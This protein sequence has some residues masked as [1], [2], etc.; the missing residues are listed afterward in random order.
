MRLVGRIL[1]KAL[2][3]LYFFMFLIGILGYFEI[4]EF[5]TNVF[6]FFKELLGNYALGLPV[7]CLIFAVVCWL[8]SGTKREQEFDDDDDDDDDEYDNRYD[9]YKRKKNTMKDRPVDKARSTEQARSDELSKRISTARSREVQANRL[10]NKAAS[11][12]ETGIPVSLAR[13]N[14]FS[15]YFAERL[16]VND[17]PVAT[18]DH[19]GH[20]GANFSSYFGEGNKSFYISENTVSMNGFKDYFK[21]SKKDIRKNN[22]LPLESADKEK[23]QDTLFQRNNYFQERQQVA[24]V[25]QVMAATPVTEEKIHGNFYKAYES[26]PS[27]NISADISAEYDY[28]DI[29][30]K[31]WILP[32]IELLRR[33]EN[34]TAAAERTTP[35]LLEDVLSTF[36]VTAKVTNI[37]VGPVITRYE[38][39]PA[40]GTK[41]SKIV[42]LAD[43]IALAMA[44]RDIRIEA[45]IPGKAAVGIEVPCQKSRT[46]YF[47]EVIGSESFM[48]SGG[49]LKI[50]L[51]KD[52]ADQPVIGELA[53]MPHLLV[54]GA[55]GSGKSI[56]INCLLNSL[57]FSY[58]PDQVKLLLI[59]PKMVELNQYNG[60]PHLLSAVVTDPK[61]ASKYL[62]FIVREMEDRY[63]L[64]ASS[65]VRDIDHYNRNMDKPLP[66]IVVVIDELADLMMVAANEIEEAICRLAQMA[67]AAGIH[68]VIATQRPSVNVITGLIKANI[69][70]RISFAVSS[71]IDSRTI[72]DGGGAEKLLGKG[73]M[74]YSPIG[75]NKPQ[76]VHGCFI[77]EQET[78]N[79]IE[80]WKKQGRSAY[81][82]DENLLEETTTSEKPD[83]D[84]DERFAEAGELV[85]TSGIA[86]VSYLQ[87][88]LRVGYSR[89]ARLMD[90]L[91]D[92]GVVGRSEGNKP[93][94]ILISLED[95]QGYFS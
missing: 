69:P 55:T 94:E 31:A 30:T 81:E 25:T 5:S 67:R 78:K 77:D 89:A 13:E 12:P 83:E 52:I 10:A 18:K 34:T 73:D 84:L 32:R 15:S 85:I 88:R 51:G 26:K 49:K 74:L 7:I 22:T 45:P 62:K 48:G 57:L 41:I 92:A 47:R 20:L 11:E 50:A 8:M 24:S 66:Y 91:E 68:L 23:K 3:L 86:S 27:V 19:L 40:P 63:E 35:E 79:V 58:T 16:F 65:G 6:S 2:S 46:V 42:N 9:E 95:F 61:K 14:G 33:R 44:S 56:F 76:R 17:E 4:Q 72:L 80:H 43:D 64:F 21:E 37:T 28:D 38:L 75:L 87:R 36:G 1:I 93:R 90:M 60:I 39:S 71:Q 70:S 59:D 82:L 54:A 29:K 53:K